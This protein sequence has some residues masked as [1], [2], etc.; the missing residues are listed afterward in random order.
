MYYNL[1]LPMI[2]FSNE[3][4]TNSPTVANRLHPV[5]MVIPTLDSRART[6]GDIRILWTYNNTS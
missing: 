5:D 4:L 3:W 6:S 2:S 1:Y